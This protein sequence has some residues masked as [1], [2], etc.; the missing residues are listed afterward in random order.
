M[1]ATKGNVRRGRRRQEVG[2]ARLDGTLMRK[3]G[4]VIAGVGDKEARS[5]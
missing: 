5:W 1:L 3:L 2:D 4:L